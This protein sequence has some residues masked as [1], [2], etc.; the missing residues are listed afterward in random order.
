MNPGLLTQKLGKAAP[1]I[2]KR[3]FKLAKYLPKLMPPPPPS[4]SY[5]QKVQDWGMMLNGVLGDCVAAAAG[6]MIQQWTRYAGTEIVIPDSAILKTYED[7]GGYIPGNS[8]TDTGMVMLDYLNY[9]RKV[10]VGGHKILGYVSVDPSRVD[11]IQAAIQLFGNLY[12][13]LQ[14]PRSVQGTSLWSVPPSGPYN[15]ASPGSWGGHC[16]PLMAYRPNSAGTAALYTPLTWAA[17]FTATAGFLHCYMDE[18]YAVLSEDW[19]E[20][21]GLAPSQFNLDQ[22][23][24][25]L[26]QL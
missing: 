8:N 14:L 17:K 16:V 20:S 6:H 7:V 9:W 3:T 21:N 22:L 5:V 19:I 11:Q 24:E 12:A 23:Q 15:N 10:G 4:A 2:D 13:G 18:C 26:S 1:K 25:D